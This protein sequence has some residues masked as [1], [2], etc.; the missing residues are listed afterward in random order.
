MSQNHCVHYNH[1]PL[2][3]ASTFVRALHVTRPQPAD[4]TQLQAI[5]SGDH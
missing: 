5:I 2:I 4:C 3:T 1:M